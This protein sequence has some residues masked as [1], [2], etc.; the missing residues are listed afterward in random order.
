MR[1][2]LATALAFA[3]L[4]SAAL[5]AAPT[6]AP[7][8]ATPAHA[9]PTQPWA[10][11]WRYRHEA[12]SDAG[13]ARDAQADTLRLRASWTQAFGP[14][15]S[16]QL[17][18]EGVVE[19][20]DRFNS[21]ANGRTQFPSVP[22]A[23]ALEIN[24]A[25]VEHR[26]TTASV[27]VGRQMLVLDN[28]RFIGNG[29]WRQNT[30]SFDALQLRWHPAPGVEVQAIHLDRVHRSAGDRARNPLARERELRAPLAR[31]A[32]TLPN[33]SLVGYGY[34]IEDEDV[35]Q[36]STRSLGL[37]WDGHWPLAG[38]WRAGLALERAQ[39]TAWADAR[40]GSTAYAAIEPRLERGPLV[41]RAGWQ[42]LGAGRDRAFQTPLGSLHG[43]QGWADQFTVT[44]L[45][46]LE[47]RWLS[48]QT[49]NSL[50]GWPAR[51]E[52]R[53]HDFQSEAGLDYGS[54]WNAALTLTPA[55]GWS[56]MLKYADYR[57]EGFSRDVRKLWLQLEVS[58]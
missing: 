47:D 27:R 43:F 22:D 4:P 26:G 38:G 8:V 34:W 42:T 10:L 17:E 54:E 20:G 37:R 13:F 58:M 16:A 3:L 24:Q 31:I 57:A 40:G 30:Q 29:A 41:L 32:W 18:A 35:P 49:D 25:W 15:W 14:R 39:Q 1:T 6:R 9:S 45:G 11:Q 55:P 36:A 48:L 46:G 44:P 56:T 53:V 5:S 33:G 52:L 2:V 23:R 28:G 51:W 12:V 50:L 21:G 19:L 7:T